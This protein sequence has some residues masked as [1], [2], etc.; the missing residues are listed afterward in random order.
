M[1]KYFKKL[2]IVPILMMSLGFVGCGESKQ[3]ESKGLLNYYMD[4]NKEEKFQKIND[5]LKEMDN[6]TVLNETES[7]VLDK[8]NDVH[9]DVNLI[10][11]VNNDKSIGDQMEIRYWK[12]TG[13][14]YSVNYFKDDKKIV[15]NNDGLFVESDYYIMD[16]D[17]VQFKV[18]DKNSQKAYINIGEFDKK[19]IDYV[20]TVIFDEIIPS[21]SY[22]KGDY[23]GNI[24]I[25]KEKIKD[26]VLF[27]IKE[28]NEIV[29]ESVKFI[30]VINERN[31]NEL[32][33]LNFDKSNTVTTVVYVADE[34]RIVGI[35][36]KNLGENQ[37]YTTNSGA[38]TKFEIR[39]NLDELRKYLNSESK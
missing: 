13:E 11:V 24:K 14:F 32:L 35:K 26:E 6:F 3:I 2:I 12:E 5:G 17:E 27:N 4:F 31:E 19:S 37:V 28:G 18:L 21:I 29:G 36:N 39:N 9:G 22:K 33:R 8:Y 10:K 30:D 16:T 7:W 34:E 23:E 38:G 15:E 25:I 1:N 20:N